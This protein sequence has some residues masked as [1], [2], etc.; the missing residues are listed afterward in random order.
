MSPTDKK[1]QEILEGLD[2]EGIIKKSIRTAIPQEAREVIGEAYVA[3]PKPYKQVSELVSQQTKTAHSEIYQDHVATLNRVSAELDTAS[4]VP[5][6]L[7]SGHCE[8]R[9]LKLDESFNLNAVW[10]HELYFANCF[11]PHSEVYM[12][13]LGFM[14]I[15]RDFDTFDDWQR[16][17][18]A[19]ALTAGEGWVVCGYNMFLKRYV[20]TVISHNSADV[21]LGLY[22]VI[23]IDVWAH[24]YFRDYLEDK[25]SYIV[26]QLRELNWNVIEER[27]Q[28]AEAMA[29]ALK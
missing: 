15:Q 12:D 21:M 14:R 6:D 11:D 23:V 22:P 7:S 2:V 5:A 26:S 27:F 18:V 20:N 13:S 3:E 10:L 1:A 16:D 24:A 17:F 4:R 29:E 8:L 19:C 25:R 28:K 9:S